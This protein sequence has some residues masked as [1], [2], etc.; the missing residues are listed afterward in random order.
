[1]DCIF[2]K[3][4]K[5]EI[6]SYTVYEDE[7]VKVFLDV[8]PTHNGHMLVVPKKHILDIDTMDGD[9]LL[10]II[11]VAKKMKQRLEKRLQANGISLIQNNGSIQEVKHFHLHIKPYYE[12]HQ[13]LLPIEQVYNII[14]E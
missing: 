6:P 9:T 10:H 3:I 5:G 14:K 7:M 1:M 13:E 12:V 11:E 2:C 8:N 4:V